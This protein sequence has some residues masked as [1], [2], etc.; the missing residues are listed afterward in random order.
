MRKL[1]TVTFLLGILTGQSS[2]ASAATYP[3]NTSNILVLENSV[4][5]LQSNIEILRLEWTKGI[6]YCDL[7]ASMYS[8]KSTVGS[9]QNYTDYH[10]TPI[11]IA[12]GW[13]IGDGSELVNLL[14]LVSYSHIVSNESIV[15]FRGDHLSRWVESSLGST[16][17]FNGLPSFLLNTSVFSLSSNRRLDLINHSEL[18]SVT[19]MSYSTL[20]SV[21]ERTGTLLVRDWQGERA[22]FSVPSNGAWIFSLVGAFVCF[23]RSS[24]R[25]A[26]RAAP[27]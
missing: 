25:H 1:L 18:Q 15:S 10:Y 11:S 19:R 7:Y 9:C 13:R 2:D 20:S 6:H 5:D 22:I 17:L 23:R 26:M 27:Q 12:D 8:R 24:S 4:V 21:Q 16:Q 14:K 3:M